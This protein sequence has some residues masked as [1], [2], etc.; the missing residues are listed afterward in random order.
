MLCRTLQ[1]GEPPPANVVRLRVPTKDCADCMRPKAGY[2]CRNA[3][4]SV[5]VM[6]LEV[7][8]TTLPHPRTPHLMCDAR[9]PFCGQLM[10]LV[11]YFEIVELAPGEEGR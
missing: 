2:R 3:A 1:P 5:S 7:D 9:C 8:S 11:S 4:C 6:L 10:R